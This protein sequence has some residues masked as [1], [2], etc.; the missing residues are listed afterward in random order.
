ARHGPFQNVEKRIC[1]VGRTPSPRG[2]T[3]PPAAESP[4]SN[5]SRRTGG[6]ID[7]SKRSKLTSTS[8]TLKK[9]SSKRRWLRRSAF[10]IVVVLR[11]AWLQNMPRAAAPHLPSLSIAKD[12]YLSIRQPVAPTQANELGQRL[13]ILTRRTRIFGKSSRGEVALIKFEV[14]R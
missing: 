14:K 13:F 7:P 1:A 6:V 10:R 4:R 3:P 2:P 11:R 5:A 8:S 12:F 9:S